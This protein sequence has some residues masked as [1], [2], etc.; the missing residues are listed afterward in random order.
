MYPIDFEKV[1]ERGP[2]QD[3]WDELSTDGVVKN[4]DLGIWNQPVQ[5]F[6]VI[7]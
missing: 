6:M 2:E 7:R 1:L 5:A 3:S 4:G